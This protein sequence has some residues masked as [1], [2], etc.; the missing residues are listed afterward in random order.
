MIKLHD[1]TQLIED[2]VYLDL[3]FQRL[4][5]QNSGENIATGGSIRKLSDHISFPIGRRKRKLEEE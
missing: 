1:Q 3:W 4:R 5:I 2:R